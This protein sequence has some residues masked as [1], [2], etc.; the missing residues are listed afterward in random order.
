MPDFV[1][2]FR[3]LRIPSSSFD[4]LLLLFGFHGQFNRL[5]G[6][7]TDIHAIEGLFGIE[8]RWSKGRTSGKEINLMLN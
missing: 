4:N 2:Y 3:F 6:A 1:G 7:D 5:D 8:T